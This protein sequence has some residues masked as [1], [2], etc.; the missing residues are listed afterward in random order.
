MSLLIE[1][2]SQN[3]IVCVSYINDQWCTHESFYY[4]DFVNKICQATWFVR[5]IREV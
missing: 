5:V 3:H 1:L 4:N 2:Y